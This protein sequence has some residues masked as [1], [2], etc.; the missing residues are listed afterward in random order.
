MHIDRIHCRLLERCLDRHSQD[1]V[2][3]CPTEYADYKSR[4]DKA[5]EIVERVNQFALATKNARSQA[6]ILSTTQEQLAETQS[7]V[8]ASGGREEVLKQRAEAQRNALNSQV[9]DMASIA[10]DVLNKNVAR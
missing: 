3:A 7:G 6:E 10:Q 2:A 5:L 8:G 1:S 4:I 9:L